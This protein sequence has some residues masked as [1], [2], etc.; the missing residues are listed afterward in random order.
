M[1]KSYLSI[2]PPLALLGLGVTAHAQSSVAIYGNLDV[3]VGVTQAGSGTTTPGGTT[4]VA[5]PGSRITRMDS[6]VGPGSRLG[7]RGTEDLGDGLKA[8]FILEAGFAVDTGASQQ[9][10]LLFGRQSLVGLSSTR[11][12]TLT[13]GRQYSPFAVA[14]GLSDATAGWFWGNPTAASGHGLYE[15]L[16]AAPGSGFFGA[17]DRMD[18][19]VQATA[20]WG[21]FTGRFMVATGNENTRGTGRFINPA[22]T[23][24]NGPFQ[25][26][27]SYARF[28]QH[29][30]AITATATPEWLSK[31]VV[32]GSYDFGVVKVFGG[33]YQFNGPK[34]TANLS[35][36][37]TSS[38][39]AYTWDKT[40]TIWLS[41]R[42]PV[43]SAGTF[44]AQVSRTS[45]DYAT[46]PDGKGTALGLLY[47]YSMSKRTTL[48][49]SYG[50]VENNAFARGPLIATITAIVPNGFGSDPRAASLG[51]RHTF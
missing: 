42:V 51:I 26:N 12:W 45:Y 11:G 34:N 23:Y 18:N 7:F 39:F 27:A 4:P 40:R 10:G 3:S 15:S 37:F 20:K 38:P 30:E 16:G 14:F 17:G 5:N 41:G 21:E 6:G 49:A 19:S 33:A 50:Q 44:T 13:A 9:G 36:A 25:V 47:E 35:T 28:R 1:K 2:L 24:E 31:W 48:Y 22:I 46:G 29:V 8:N 43:G 32:G